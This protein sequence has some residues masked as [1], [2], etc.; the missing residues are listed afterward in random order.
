MVLTMS[1]AERGSDYACDN[2][3]RW[4]LH[5]MHGLPK[6]KKEAKYWYKRAT[7]GS[8]SVRHLASRDMEKAKAKLQELETNE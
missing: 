1:A 3:G 2:L 8:C 4:Y 5:G 7:D 6:D